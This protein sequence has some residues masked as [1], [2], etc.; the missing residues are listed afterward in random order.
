MRKNITN[1]EL[2]I[3]LSWIKGEITS[4]QFLKK[5]TQHFKW[6]K[7]LISTMKNSDIGKGDLNI[8]I[9]K[10]DFEE[11]FEN[12]LEVYEKLNIKQIKYDI[13][14]ANE[15]MKQIPE[16]EKI[17]NS[18]NFDKEFI[19]EELKKIDNYYNIMDNILMNYDFQSKNL[20]D[21]Q[22]KKLKKKLEIYIKNEEYEKCSEI[23]SLIIKRE[24]NSL[25]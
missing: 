20:K 4:R 17:F 13:K 10:S 3:I 11:I 23:Q 19:Q 14:N 8:D 16:M 24:T 12:S 18:V 6:S 15:T 9:N 25:L 7:L 2:M 5:E 21:K 22:L 1:N